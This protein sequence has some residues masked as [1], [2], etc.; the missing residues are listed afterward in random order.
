MNQAPPRS[1]ALRPTVITAND[2]LRDLGLG[3]L[4]RFREVLY[5]L[6]WRDF[7]VRYRQTALGVAWALL[8]PLLTAAVLTLLF[9]RLTQAPTNGAPYPL[10]VIAGLAPW[11]FFTHGVSTATQSMANN[12]DLVRRIYFPRIAI[13]LSAVLSGLFDLLVGLVLLLVVLAF[14]GQYLSPSLLLAP[15][16][17]LLAVVATT[18][19]GLIL[20]A[21]NVRYRDVSYAVPFAL[22][23]ALFVS[24]IAYASSALPG[25]WRLL[26]SLNPMVGVVDGLR[27]AVFHAPLDPWSLLV[28]ISAAV[29]ALALG[30]I[31]FRATERTVADIL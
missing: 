9:S 31:Y 14:Y 1:A 25:G 17:L 24:P 29:A 13:P 20:S 3:E 19:V 22:Q 12:Q 28:S 2:K 30:V 23:I 15:L 4:W 18:G 16:F 5:F 26:Y 11:Q 6:V 7:Q 27:W 10:F 8:Q 21:A